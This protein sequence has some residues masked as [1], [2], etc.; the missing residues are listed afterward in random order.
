M[1]AATVETHTMHTSGFMKITLPMKLALFTKQE[2]GIT[3]LDA[4]L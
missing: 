1:T 3:A 2:A 4:V